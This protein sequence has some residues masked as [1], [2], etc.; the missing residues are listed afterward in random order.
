MP[1]IPITYEFTFCCHGKGAVRISRVR[2]RASPRREK[3]RGS[4]SRYIG[5]SE[6]CKVICA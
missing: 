3:Q 6:K 1:L 5:P 2:R 4:S